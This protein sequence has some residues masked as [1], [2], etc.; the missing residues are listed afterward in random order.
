MIK[1]GCSEQCQLF[2]KNKQK[3]SG[4]AYLSGCQLSAKNRKQI[5]SDGIWGG[6]VKNKKYFKVG[7]NSDTSVEYKMA[8]LLNSF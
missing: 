6:L 7:D 3:L 4:D 8:L 1:P 5:R 2:A